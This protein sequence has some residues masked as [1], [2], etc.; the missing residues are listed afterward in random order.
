[1]TSVFRESHTEKVAENSEIIEI[2]VS[3]GVVQQKEYFHS[4]FGLLRYQVNFK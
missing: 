2:R 4:R 1:M 3:T